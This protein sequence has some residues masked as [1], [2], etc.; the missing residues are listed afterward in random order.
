MQCA[1]L[2]GVGR[3][4]A[5]CLDA[6][7]LCP[8]F[9]LVFVLVPDLAPALDYGG[10]EFWD[11]MGS[12]LAVGRGVLLSR[13]ARVFRWRRGVWCFAAECNYTSIGK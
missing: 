9:L 11:G 6:E 12:S 7:C 1:A 8:L 2:P 13:F 5:G 10:A 3:W 4:G